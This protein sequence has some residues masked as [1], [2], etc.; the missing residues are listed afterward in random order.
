[1]K[2]LKYLLVLIIIISLGISKWLYYPQYQINKMKKSVVEIRSDKG[3]PVSF[4]DYFRNTK[5]TK[6][7]HLA[8]GDSIIRGLGAKPN[9]DFVYQ[10]ST[11]LGKQINKEIQFQNEGINGITSGELNNII[12]EGLYDEDIKKANIV[13]V[14]V[15][16]NDILRLASNGDYRSILKSIERLKADYSANLTAIASRI[17]GLNANATIVFLELYNPFSLTDQVYPLADKLLPKWNLLVYEVANQYP[18]S[19]VVETTKVINGDNLN[20]LSKDGV[21]P[22]SD[23][24]LAISEQLIY[25]FTHQYRKK[26]V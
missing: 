20:F 10:F 13:T 15:G 11:Q 4:I 1:M 3:A 25:Q 14:N 16:G 9:E 22:N 6:L 7:Y 19:L 24:Y 5:A 12:Q 17:N 21:H 8:L 2:S 26:D 23:G 18:S